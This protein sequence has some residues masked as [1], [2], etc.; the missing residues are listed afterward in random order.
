MGHDSIELGRAGLAARAAEDRV[1]RL[2][3]RLAKDARNAGD[4]RREDVI[5]EAF[6]GFTQA[7]SR[8]IDE[9]RDASGAPADQIHRDPK[10]SADWDPLKREIAAN[11]SAELQ[12]LDRQR[13]RLAELL[14]SIDQS[15]LAR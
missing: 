12:A 5:D 4:T 8:R 2:A 11:L 6:A 13:E 14:R 15:S 10:A 3:T 9:R 7:S 1:T